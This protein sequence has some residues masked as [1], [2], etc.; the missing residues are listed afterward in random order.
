VADLFAG[1]DWFL[2][3]AEDVGAIS[4]QERTNLRSRCW[5][6]FCRS[7]DAQAALHRAHE[8]AQHFMRLLTAALATG[9]VH[10]ADRN[11]NEPQGSPEAWGWRE[12]TIG[13]GQYARREW[14]PRGR[15]IGWIDSP[16]L[17]LDPDAAFAE[18]H[19]FAESQGDG[20]AISATVMAKRLNE[21]GYLARTDESRGTLTVRSKLQGSPRNVWQ[22]SESQVTGAPHD[23]YEDMEFDDVGN[24]GKF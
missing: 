14:Q 12:V 7:A 8:P 5:T 18:M 19:K 17:F 22:L 13:G 15:L 4:S 21:A 16:H 1:F 11:G 24:V 2:R 23:D 3:F 20:I 9:L 10:L 6:A